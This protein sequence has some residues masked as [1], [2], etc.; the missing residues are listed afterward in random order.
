MNIVDMF[1]CRCRGCLHSVQ[2]ICSRPLYQFTRS[3]ICFDLYSCLN[4]SGIPCGYVRG[5][6]ALLPIVAR[7]GK[8]TFRRA[9]RHFSREPTDTCRCSIAGHWHHDNPDRTLWKVTHFVAQ[10][11]FPATPMEH[12]YFSFFGHKPYYG[13]FIDIPEIT[14]NFDLTLIANVILVWVRSCGQNSRLKCS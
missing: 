7:A 11:R 10:M 3:E 5:T 14:S 12:I 13:N 9:G 6:S 1:S 4:I 2:H 8:S